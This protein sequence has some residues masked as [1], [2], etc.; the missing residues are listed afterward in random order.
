METKRLWREWAEVI[1][2]IAVMVIEVLKKQ[3]RGRS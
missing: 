1:I 3:Q 2:A